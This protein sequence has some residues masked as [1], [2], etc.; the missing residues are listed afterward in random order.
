MACRA[1]TFKFQIQRQASEALCCAAKSTVIYKICKPTVPFENKSAETSSHQH[2]HFKAAAA[3][4]AG[5][6]ADEKAHQLG[7]AHLQCCA[8][9]V[10]NDTQ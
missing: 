7:Y 1:Q 2:V 4:A 5:A 8:Q 10:A 6:A 9:L 3:A